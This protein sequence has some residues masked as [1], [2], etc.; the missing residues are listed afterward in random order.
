MLQGLVWFGFKSEVMKFW[1]F[2]DNLL[3]EKDKQMGF[4]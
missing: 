1:I 4:Q 3:A 2:L